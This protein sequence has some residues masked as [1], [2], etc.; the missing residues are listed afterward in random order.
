MIEIQKCYA[1]NGTKQEIIDE[2]FPTINN[3]S[4]LESYRKD[5]LVRQGVKHVNDV[6]SKG[7]TLIPNER[8]DI[9]FQTREK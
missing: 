6:L 9:Y 8:I 7:E 1:V 5:L 2:V 3:R 4:E